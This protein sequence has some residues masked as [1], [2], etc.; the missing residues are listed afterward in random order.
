MQ[1]IIT[2]ELSS[3]N[4][5]FAAG[6][7]TIFSQEERENL[8]G[9]NFKV[10]CS[11]EALM[12]PNGLAFDYKK[13]KDR[14]SH[15]CQQL[16]E[17]LLLP[18][19]SPYLKVEEQADYYHCYFNHEKLYF[20]KRDAVLL[21]IRNTTIEDLAGWFLQGL[22]NEFD[23]EDKINIQSLTVKVSSSPSQTGAATWKK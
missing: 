15:T 8:H 9:H 5:K 23:D 19:L 14:I 3:S 16:D 17:V 10:A 18:Q 21:P 4:M 2:I 7:F 1:P 6:H 11:I 12:G 22:I 13:F 20:L